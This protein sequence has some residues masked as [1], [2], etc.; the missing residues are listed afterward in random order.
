MFSDE[1]FLYGG[2]DIAESMK[3]FMELN[4]LRRPFIKA[5]GT[6]GEDENDKEN[7]TQLMFDKSEDKENK[8]VVRHSPLGLRAGS[9]FGL[10]ER[11]IRTLSASP[12]TAELSDD[13]HGQEWGKPRKP[14]KDIRDEDEDVFS[15]SPSADSFAKRLQPPSSSSSQ[16]ASVFGNQGQLELQF[17]DDEHAVAKF[18]LQPGFSD[19]FKS[20]SNPSIVSTVSG[21]FSQWS[22]AEVFSPLQLGRG[23]LLIWRRMIRALINYENPWVMISP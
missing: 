16:L 11:R 5:E 7:N 12:S 2:A 4:T 15:F 1:A 14:L 10:E 21:G 19:I 18:S 9:S 8:A 17:Q 3:F 6:T 23:Y 13:G 20:G 22:E